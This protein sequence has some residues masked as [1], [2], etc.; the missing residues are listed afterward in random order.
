MLK[1]LWTM[2]RFYD[3][4]MHMHPNICPDTGNVT[5]QQLRAL[6]PNIFVHIQRSAMIPL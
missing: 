3:E 2:L 6:L 4:F 5:I 1:A